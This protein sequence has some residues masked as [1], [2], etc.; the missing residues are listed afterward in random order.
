L[1]SGDIR[2][3]TTTKTPT[4]SGLSPGEGFRALFA[5]P[6]TVTQNV[7]N[8]TSTPTSFP[9][10]LPHVPGATFDFGGGNF[11]SEGSFKFGGTPAPTAAGPTT[12][13]GNKRRRNN[14]DESPTL[15]RSR[16]N[17]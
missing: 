1:K 14:D 13:N 8:S 17:V 12:G 15:K 10:G 4:I 5:A 16:P 9:F 3:P 7:G 6:A 11:F 2:G